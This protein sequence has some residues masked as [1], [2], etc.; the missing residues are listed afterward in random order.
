MIFEKVFDIHAHIGFR[1][2][3]EYRPQDALQRMDKNNIIKAVIATFVTGLI[4]K[5]DFKKANDYIIKAVRAYPDR[6]IG[7]SAITP[8]HGGFAL[9]EF[10]RG[11]ENGLSGIKLHPDKGGSYSLN[12]KVLL[13]IMSKIEDLGALVFIHSDFNSKNC[14][15]YSIADLARKFPRAK[16]LMGHFGLEQ[17]LCESVPLVVKSIKNIF[18]DTSQTADDPEAIYVNS[19]KQLGVSRVLFG[20]DAPVISPE[21]NL[22][23]LEIAI[24]YYNLV[25]SEVKAILWNNAIKLLNNVPNAKL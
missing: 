16:I 4:E 23:K 25:D 17:E 22:K 12:N 11:L 19:I 21:V 5:S 15:P 24:E 7:L 10:Q 2:G 1:K 6:F 13:K 3:K 9:K 20:S 8:L 14:S 18:L